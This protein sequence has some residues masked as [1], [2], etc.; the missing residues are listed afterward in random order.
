MTIPSTSS[1]SDIDVLRWQPTA[2]MTETALLDGFVTAL[3]SAEWGERIAALTEAGRVASRTGRAVLQL[4]CIELT[5]ERLR[6]APLKRLPNAAERCVM[7]DTGE[8]LSTLSALSAAGRER[9][10][11]RLRS[12]LIGH[13]SLIG[14]FHLLRTATMRRSQGF[15]V[16]FAGCE[17]DVPFDLLI[18]RAGVAAEVACDVLSAE[19][20]RSIQRSAWLRLVDAL[21]RELQAWLRSNPGRYLMKMT[22]HGGLHAGDDAVQAELKTRIRKTLVR[23]TQS[24]PDGAATLRLEPLTLPAADADGPGLMR[25]LRDEFG[26]EAH[27]AIISAGGSVLALAART[28]HADEVA[29]A[30]NRHLKAAAPARLSG[31]HPGVLA[32]FIED[33]DRLEWRLLRETLALEGEIRRFMTH[34]EAVSVAAVSCTSRLELFDMASAG[35]E[36]RGEVRFRNPAHPS[37]KLE[38][39]APAV[40]SSY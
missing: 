19:A 24:E 20:G 1:A 6:R 17:M 36:P 27:L 4:H 40:S 11:A 9:F 37:A 33:V 32:L 39:L 2:N 15:E 35:A 13:G 34:E 3:G 26:P 29:A 10:L 22:L 30:V 5:I 16:Q 25:R 21:D 38:A 7:M 18:R 12:S 14:V 31:Q 23:R 8:A 28:G